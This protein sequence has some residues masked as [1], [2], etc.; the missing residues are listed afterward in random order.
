MRTDNTS[1]GLKVVAVAGTYVVVLGFDLPEADCNGLLGFSI[2]RV[3]HNENEAYYLSGM[4]AFALT[5]PGFVAGSLYSTKDHPIQGFQWADYSAKPGYQ[6]T[7]TVAALKGTPDNL[8][9]FAKT[10]VE[11]TTEKP[12]TATGNHN[13]YFNRGTA[14]SQEYVRRFGN[15]KPADVANNK[16]WEWLSRGLYEALT[17][18]ISSCPGRVSSPV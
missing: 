4:K 10:V 14:A 18:F 8:V 6:Y 12:E 13:V 17:E 9:E 3:D 16:A 7:Y 5:D 15:D 1:T 11:V 2:H